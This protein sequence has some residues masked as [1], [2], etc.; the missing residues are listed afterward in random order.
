MNRLKKFKSSSR[1]L[2]RSIY[3]KM[4]YK[5]PILI[6]LT[7]LNR[8]IG[9]YL[10]LWPTISALYVAAEG[11]PSSSL[12]LIF[13]LG[14]IVMRSAGC[15]INDFADQGIDGDV[16]RT[17]KRPLVSGALKRSEALVY[18][19]ILSSLGFILVL[20]TNIETILVS[21]CSIAIIVLY[22][23]AK[24]FTNLP[25][26]ILG[27]AF[28]CGILMAFT[29]TTKNI[30]EIAYL[31]FFANV[32]WT[33]AYDTQYAMVDREFDLKIGVKSTAILFG[34]ADRLAIG[35]LQAGFLT[36]FSLLGHQLDFNYGF[37]V[38]LSGA[39]LLLIYQ[40]YLIKDRVPDLCF[41]A[42]ANNNW[43]GLL[44]FAGILL[45]YF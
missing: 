34:N 10:L 13:L 22:P 27:I 24:R 12:L 14:T 5:I 8:P 35:L 44:I 18:F 25:Q 15:C 19:G 4:R 39:G 20:F 16:K 11:L 31:L 9:I 40:Q 1:C 23:F 30:P 29:A 45:N 7:R 43:V 42:F 38:A 17:E 21:I 32:L 41:K 33:I 6:E 28:S 36:A 2:L 3:L 37:Y 26:V